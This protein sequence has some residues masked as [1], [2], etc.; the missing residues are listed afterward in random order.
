MGL[1]QIVVT[2]DAHWGGDSDVAKSAWVSTYAKEAAAARTREDVD[3]VVSQI[4]RQRHGTPKERVWLEFFITCPIFVERQLDKYRMTEQH[5]DITVEYLAARMGRDNLTQNELS[6]RYRT[7]PNRPYVMPRDVRAIVMAAGL[8]PTDLD[9]VL[10]DQH[11]HYERWLGE[12]RQARD[13]G[14]IKPDEYKRAREVYRGVL[15]TG[16][17]TDM[18]LLCNLRAFESILNERLPATAQVESRV[19]AFYMAEAVLTAH[20]ADTTLNNMIAVN[21]WRGQLEA[22]RTLLEEDRDG[23]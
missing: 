23:T 4:V 1:S 7:V 18:R 9:D 15:G 10:Q 13:R 11:E 19:V 14:D 3:R 8:Y 2:L 5:Q 21:G 20:V 22:I 16:Y 12:L 6:G 17:L